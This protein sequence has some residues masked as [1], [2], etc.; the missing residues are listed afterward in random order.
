M[1]K[2]VVKRLFFD[3]SDLRSLIAWPYLY[4]AWG[5]SNA[6][7][8]EK[9]RLRHEAEAMLDEWESVYKVHALL[10]LMPANSDDDD[11][12]VGEEMTRIPMLR[13]QKAP[14]LCL[15]DYLRPADSGEKDEIGLFCTS[16]ASD[17]ETR[18]ADDPYQRMLS[19]T[20]ADRLAEA[21]SEKLS[22]QMPGIR[23]AVGYPSMPDMSINFLLD[24][25]LDMRQ[26]GISLT[27]SGMMIPHAS[28]SGLILSHPKAEYFNIQQIGDDQL[29]DYAQRRG[30]SVEKIR[31][32]I[33]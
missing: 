21:A 10:M 5:I 7:D 14:F 9:Q 19:Q 32:F 29:A 8:D 16:V 30:M 27:E 22:T 11:I 17:I 26:I 24:E 18:Y 4:W 12:L 33:K 15:A 31:R 13:Q 20:L 2:A 1:P 25:L 23:P 6:P 28:V 3:V